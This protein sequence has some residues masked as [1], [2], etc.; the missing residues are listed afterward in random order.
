LRVRR[1]QSAGRLF[2]PARPCT[3]SLRGQTVV[4]L[5]GHVPGISREQI[6]AR[7]APRTLGRAPAPVPERSRAFHL[8]KCCQPGLERKGWRRHGFLAPCPLR[9]ARALLTGLAGVPGG[10][11]GTGWAGALA[12]PLPS[13]NPSGFLKRNC[14]R[15]LDRSRSTRLWFGGCAA[16]RL[17]CRPRLSSHQPLAG[18]PRS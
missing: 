13:P 7:R 1:R 17:L 10:P 9:R 12:L 2:P 6:I 5:R 8:P 15:T 18:T 3:C 16:R 4:S 14:P 11:V